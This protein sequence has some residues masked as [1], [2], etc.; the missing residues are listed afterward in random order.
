MR[1]LVLYEHV[2]KGVEG[3][4]SMGSIVCEVFV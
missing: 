3:V 4:T 2:Y 1:G